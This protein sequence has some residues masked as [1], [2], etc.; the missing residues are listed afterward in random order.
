MRKNIRHFQRPD[1]VTISE[2]LSRRLQDK[3][4][5]YRDHRDAV[6][7]HSFQVAGVFYDYSRDSGVMLMQRAN[8]EK[9]WHD[10]RVNS[11][12]LYLRPGTDVEK[13]IGTIRT[14]YAAAGD[15]S[16]YSNRALREAVVEVFNQTFAVTQILRLIAVLVAVIG[17]AL[18][19]TVLVKE[20]ERE[21][22]TLRAARRFTAT[23][24]RTDHLGIVVSGDRWR[25]CSEW[26]P[27]SRFR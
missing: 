1:R 17:I 6:G 27:G 21:I 7:P 11:V 16:L 10:S 24:S 12:S 22:G 19:I 2:P 23:D 15:Y 13:V 20:R 9:F 25:F 26:P 14:G 4:G 18:N 8:F 5:R 3:S